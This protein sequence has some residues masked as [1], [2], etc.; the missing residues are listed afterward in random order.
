MRSLIFLI[1]MGWAFPLLAQITVADRY[2]PYQPIIAG[3]NCIVPESGTV[4]FLWSV[5]SQSKAIPSEDNKKLYIWAPPGNHS[6]DV[7]AIT[8][9][10]QELNVW[11]EDPKF[12][13]DPTKAIL[14]KIKSMLSQDVQRY[15]KNYTVGT[16]PPGPSPG[17]GPAPGPDPTPPGPGPSPGPGPLDDFTTNALS[18]LKAIPANNYSKEKAYSIADNYSAIAAQAVATSGWDLNAFVNQT[19]QLNQKKLST[20]DIAAWSQPFFYPLAN[21]QSKL[22]TERKLDT[23]DAM[24]IAKLWNDT[25]KAIKG[26][27]DAKVGDTRAE[28]VPVTAE[29]PVGYF[30]LKQDGERF[31][32]LPFS[33]AHLYPEQV[34][35]LTTGRFGSL[36]PSLGR[37]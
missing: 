26:A 30:N 19:K 27:A 29:S 23:K 1:M 6:V 3:C 37:K 10:Y 22:F 11:V 24:G 5:D 35:A 14:K 7:V 8:T 34:R 4:Q 36:S 12:P 25:A 2:E 9:V 28:M 33:V 32:T 13:G 18:W 16:A 15:N 31:V 20:D 17:P 21:H